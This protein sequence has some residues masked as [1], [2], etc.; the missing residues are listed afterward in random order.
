MDVPRIV[1]IPERKVVGLKIRTSPAENRTFELCSQFKPRV[2]QITNLKNSDFY[3]IQVF[4]EDLEFSRFTP[5][6]FFEKWAA[7][8]VESFENL[9]DGLN[10]FIIPAG[11]YAIFI[12]KGLPSEFPKTS[13]YIFGEWLHSSEFELDNRP[14]FEIMDET[15]RPDDRDAEEQIWIPI[16]KK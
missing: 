9:P 12:H 6:T 13:R 1:T 16:R 4:D 2:K 5:Q 11:R 7:V 10:P 14:H 3:S 8:E 15:Y